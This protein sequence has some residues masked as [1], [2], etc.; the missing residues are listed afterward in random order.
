[1]IRW[2]EAEGSLRE[3]EQQLVRDKLGDEAYERAYHA[4]AQLTLAPA[5]DLALSRIAQ[6]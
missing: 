4:G 2:A 3:R 5:T 6:I 1:M